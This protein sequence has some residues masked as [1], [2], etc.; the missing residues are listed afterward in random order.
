MRICWIL[1]LSVAACSPYSFPKEVS[2]I[3]TGVDQLSSGF[4]DG[5]TALAA[6]RATQ[7]ELDLTATRAKV[8][9]SDSCYAPLPTMS[10]YSKPC[11][12]F[13]SGTSEPKPMAIELQ[14]GKTMAALGVL[15][16]YAHALA[17]VTSAADRAAYDT[18]VAQLSAA[19]GDLRARLKEHE[20]MEESIVFPALKRT[21]YIDELDSISD[22]MKARRAVA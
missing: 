9:I 13:K 10:E 12:L 21:L 2:A 15:K 18:A 5:Y 16:D 3:S 22:E 14:R 19:V 4:T 20:A 7:T 17:A 1:L 6:D 8:A 11:E